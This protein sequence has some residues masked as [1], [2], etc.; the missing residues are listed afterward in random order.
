MFPILRPLLFKKKEPI[1]IVSM[2]TNGLPALLIA[3]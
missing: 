2:A 3:K 1:N